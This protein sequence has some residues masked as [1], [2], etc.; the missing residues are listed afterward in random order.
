MMNTVLFAAA[1]NKGTNLVVLSFI[2]FS[3]RFLSAADDSMSTVGAAVY[4]DSFSEQPVNNN[5]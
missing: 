3:L 2:S 4:L 5:S 1:I